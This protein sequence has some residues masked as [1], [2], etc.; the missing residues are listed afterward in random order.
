MCFFK[1]KNLKDFSK[2]SKSLKSLKKVSLR[3]LSVEIL[4]F[5]LKKLRTKN[6]KYKKK[7]KMK[8]RSLK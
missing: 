3:K 5:F 6:K 7:I 2:S 4:V 1:K 8:I